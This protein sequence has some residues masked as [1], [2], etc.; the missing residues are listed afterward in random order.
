MKKYVYMAVMF[1]IIL[2]LYI[3]RSLQFIATIAIIS[4]MA[5]YV[6]IYHKQFFP[7]KGGDDNE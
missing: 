7:A 4:S 5:T 2:G 1:S 6:G 3:P